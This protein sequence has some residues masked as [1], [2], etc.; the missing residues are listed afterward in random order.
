[1]IPIGQ[2]VWAWGIIPFKAS[3]S[4]S[5]TSNTPIPLETLNELGV[6]QVCCSELCALVLTRMGKVYI[7]FTN[8]EPQVSMY[9]WQKLYPVIKEYECVVT[10]SN[11]V[12]WS[13]KHKTHKED[14]ECQ[15][16]MVCD[17]AESVALIVRYSQKKEYISF[18]FYCFENLSIA[19][20]LEPPVRF[21]WRFQQN[22]PLLM[23]PSIK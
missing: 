11:C 15:Q 6:V 20:M 13:N 23:R 5:N 9:L 19:I 12:P 16:N 1:M 18:V 21:R 17:Q 8:V 2:E 10:T 14:T 7:Q 22:V 3:S 4:S